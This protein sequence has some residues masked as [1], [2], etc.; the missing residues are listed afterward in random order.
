MRPLQHASRF[1]SCVL[2]KCNIVCLWVCF[3]ISRCNLKMQNGCVHHNKWCTQQVV[4]TTSCN[5]HEIL[6]LDLFL[7]LTLPMKGRLWWVWILFFHGIMELGQ[8]TGVWHT[9]YIVLQLAKTY[10]HTWNMLNIFWNFCEDLIIYDH[11]QT[12]WGGKE[13]TFTL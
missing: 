3:R 11:R 2:P 8:F 12:G 1:W 10:I 7:I 13:N 9:F 4:Y 5:F 6:V